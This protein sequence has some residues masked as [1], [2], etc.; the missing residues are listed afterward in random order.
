MA[1]PIPMPH[2]GPFLVEKSQGRVSVHARELP[3][4]P[5]ATALDRSVVAML[6]SGTAEPDA[7]SIGILGAPDTRWVA[8]R[9]SGEPGSSRGRVPGGSCQGGRNAR[10][11]SRPARRKKR[12]PHTDGVGPR[13]CGSRALLHWRGELMAG[14]PGAASEWM[15]TP[16]RLLGGETPLRPR[17]H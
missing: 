1:N 14:D 5:D 12:A 10:H 15:T 9:C 16:H 7:Q 17:F 4:E 8:I 11:D 13:G 2:P 6:T 3:V